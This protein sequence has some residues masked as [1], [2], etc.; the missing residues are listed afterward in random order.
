MKPITSR[1]HPLLHL[2]ILLDTRS[3]VAVTSQPPAQHS[4]HAD[5]TPINLLSTSTRNATR[6]HLGIGE[7]EEEMEKEQEGNVAKQWSDTKTGMGSD[8]QEH[9]VTQVHQEAVN[10]D[11]HN[12]AEEEDE[13]N[14]S[15]LPLPSRPGLALNT[16]HVTDVLEGLRALPDCSID[17]VITSSPYNKRGLQRT[18]TGLRDVPKQKPFGCW[19]KR[20][21]YD[22]CS[23]D[24]DEDKYQEQQIEV[25]NELHRVLKEDGTVWMNHKA[26]RAGF[27][28]HM[29]T[30]FILKSKLNLYGHVVW[31][32][33]RS[34]NQHVGFLTPVH[35]YLYQLTKTAAPPAFF[36]KRLPMEFRSSVWTI[37][38][39]RV[40][41]H[42]CPFPFQLAENCILASTANRN[43]IVLDCYAGSGTTLLAAKKLQRNFIG[44]DA[45]AKYQ[46]IFQ[47]R[48]QA[49]FNESPPTKH[50]MSVSSHPNTHRGRKRRKS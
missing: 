49:M 2:Q 7:K 11:E 20:I 29:P 22:E 44:I 46:R 9:D 15:S 5:T 17:C 12:D 30:D 39:E 16:L 8:G 27:K 32:L 38:P 10:V 28:E 43:A 33:K 37:K 47:H 48:Y 14:T 26:R 1:S 45:S 25:L 3:A 35:E 24:L 6:I 4:V 31:N 40:K 13:G 23:D 18:V 34:V 36:K 50:Q 19:H 42:P 41:G 21:N